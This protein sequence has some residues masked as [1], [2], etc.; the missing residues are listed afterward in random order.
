MLMDENNIVTDVTFSVTLHN[1]NYFQC[2]VIKMDIYWSKVYQLNCE[3]SSP[4]C[5][6]VLAALRESTTLVYFSL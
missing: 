4:C 2:V 1:N 3:Q 5:P 6:M